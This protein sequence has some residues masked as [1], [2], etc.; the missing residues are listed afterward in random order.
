VVPLEGGWHTSV[1][2]LP[3][4]IGVSLKTVMNKKLMGIIAGSLILILLAAVIFFVTKKPKSSSTNQPVSNGQSSQGAAETIEGSIKSLLSAG[5]SLKCTFSNSTDEVNVEGTVYVSGGKV[6][7]DYK[8]TSSQF[9]SSGHVIVDSENSYMWT[10]SSDQGFKFPIDNG[11]QRAISP[12]SGSENV[13]VN[14]N[15]KFS[16]GGWIADNSLFVIPS[17]INFQTLSIPAIGTVAPTAGSSGTT[18]NP[19]ENCAVCNNIPA[20]AARD[21]CL[22]QLNCD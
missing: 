11:E 6:R 8:T 20:G 1:Q 2:F 22:A 13:D 12:A 7:Q 15:Y 16:C 3:D 17:N 18:S 21:N 14:K 10:D 19:S 4:Q 5:K 9:S